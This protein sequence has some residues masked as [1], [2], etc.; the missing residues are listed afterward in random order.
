[1]S[2]IKPGPAA[3]FEQCL[4]EG[5]LLV[6]AISGDQRQPWFIKKGKGHEFL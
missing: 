6:A 5:T 4:A 3:G 1:V 2:G